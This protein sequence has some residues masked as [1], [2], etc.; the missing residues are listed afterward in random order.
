MFFQGSQ[1]SALLGIIG[2]GAPE[3][4]LPSSSFEED[5]D[6]AL[7]AALVAPFPDLNAEPER[8]ALLAAILLDAAAES[9]EGGLRSTNT[10]LSLSGEGLEE[11]SPRKASISRAPSPSSSRADMNAADRASG[12]EESCSDSGVR[13]PDMVK[14]RR[15]ENR[16]V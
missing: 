1:S 5:E 10:S 13:R 15:D 9:F 2:L 12:D 3:E 4:P 16:G 8:A 11:S 7:A 6:A 14:A